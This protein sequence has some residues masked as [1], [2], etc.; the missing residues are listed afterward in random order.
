MDISQYKKQQKARM[1]EGVLDRF[2]H[3]QNGDDGNP[4]FGRRVG[5]S[6]SWSGRA[7]GGAPKKEDDDIAYLRELA[8]PGSFS[9][10]NSNTYD[11]DSS[12]RRSKFTAVS[13]GPRVK[14][15]EGI[16]GEI[17]FE[18]SF[19]DDEERN[20]GDDYALGEE[21]T[22][23]L[24][25]RLKREMAKAEEDAAREEADEDD[26]LFDD[27]RGRKGRRE[28]DQ[29][30]GSGKQMRKIMRALG[31][32]EGNEAYDEDDE[33]RDPYASEVSSCSLVSFDAS[34]DHRTLLRT[35]TTKT[36]L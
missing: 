18:E 32:R 16:Y 20:E 31:R 4:A 30:T 12:S 8:L 9:A 17:D 7:G 2:I 13:S 22:K 29:L 19:P 23:E 5:G 11:R 24:E 35:L 34:A 10:S 25:Q 26:D 15:E 36:R 28:D 1:G 21:E 27:G 6:S 33:D 14:S 3:R